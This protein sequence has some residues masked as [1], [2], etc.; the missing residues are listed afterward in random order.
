MAAVRDDIEPITW[1]KKARLALIC[2]AQSRGASEHQHPFSFFL[3][4]PEARRVRLS[5]RHNSLDAYAR[6]GQQNV[7]AFDCAGIG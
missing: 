5:E 6:T 1:T 4:I 7:D 3:V 2:K